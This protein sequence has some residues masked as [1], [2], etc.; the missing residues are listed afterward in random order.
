VMLKNQ[1]IEKILDSSNLYSDTK[2]YMKFNGQF[3]IV[4]GVVG[5]I[6]ALVNY[7]LPTYSNYIVII[8]ISIILIATI[9]QKLIGNKYKSVK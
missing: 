3:N 4:L 5:A 7:M 1:K 2:K 9:A 8:F 6:L